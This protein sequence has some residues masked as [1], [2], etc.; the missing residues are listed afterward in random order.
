MS[1]LPDP[2]S[3]LQ[4]DDLALFNELLAK[5]GSLD[6]MYRTLLNHPELTK[7]VSDLGTYLRFNSTLEG[8]YREFIIL[9][10]A[11]HLKIGYEWIKHLEPAV[12]AGLDTAIIDAI[13]NDKE[14][15][16]PYLTLSL[17][18]LHTA[19]LENI[20]EAIQNK[21]I[22]LVGVKGLLELVVLVGFY[23]MIAGIIT[24]FDVP[25]P[26]NGHGA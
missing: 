8:K 10:S 7:H 15:P 14:L 1:R 13:K 19:K 22:T 23:R 24:S 9:F 18:V 20:P 12:Q 16:E 5:R 26:A 6:G 3:Q 25:L 2:V 21:I 11:H 17:A 4:G